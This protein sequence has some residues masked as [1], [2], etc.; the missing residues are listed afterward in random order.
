MGI[1]EIC[2]KLG[3]NETNRQ[4]WNTTNLYKSLHSAWTAK[5]HKFLQLILHILISVK[6]EI[7]FNQIPTLISP[8]RIPAPQQCVELSACLLATLHILNK[9][10][11]T[12]KTY[13]TRYLELEISY[14]IFYSQ[15]R[16]KHQSTTKSLFL[17]DRLLPERSS[18]S[19]II[20]QLHY[21]TSI[22][23]TFHNITNNQ[24]IISIFINI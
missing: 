12:V 18:L 24:S 5:L 2:A 14:S 23:S 8:S 17:S 22:V 19:S 10:P 4:K 6:K 20:V 9:F 3:T 15:I 11:H 1:Q 21:I 16:Q 13:D 7:S